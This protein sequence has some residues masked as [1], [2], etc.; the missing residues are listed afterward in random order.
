MENSIDL[1]RAKGPISASYSYFIEMSHVASVA[2]VLS[3]ERITKLLTRLPGCTEWSSPHVTKLG[4][5]ATRSIY[6]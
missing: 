6:Q 3:I 5:V 4:F 2:V 1:K